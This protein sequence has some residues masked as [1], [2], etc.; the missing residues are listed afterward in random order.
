MYVVGD[1]GPVELENGELAAGTGKSGRRGSFNDQAGYRDLDRNDDYTQHRRV[2][3]D[4]F[5]KLYYDERY[6]L[7]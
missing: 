1:G 2:N 6:D 4:N 3:M 7:S 5:D